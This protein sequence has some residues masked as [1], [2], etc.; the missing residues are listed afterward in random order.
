[1]KETLLLITPHMSTGGCPQVVAKKVELLKDTYNIICVEWECIAYTFVVQRNKVI[2]SLGD[3]FISLGENKEYELFNIIDDFNPQYIMIEELSE[4]FIPNN[5]LKRLYKSDREY[6]IIESTHSSYSN[7]QNKKFL[8][9]KFIFVC[10]H[11]A[12]VFKELDIP[13]DVIEYPVDIKEKHQLESQEKLNL[14]PEWKHVFNIGLFTPGK[15]QG[16][17]FDMCT[18]LE[19][20]KIKFHFIGNMAGNFADYWKPLL[21][22]KPEN[23]VIWG[24]R[25]DVDTFIQA[26]DLFLFPSLLELNPISIKEVL[27]YKVPSMFYNLPIYYNKYND[28]ENITM[29]TGSI[30]KDCENLLSIIK[31]TLKEPQII[32][33]P[34]ELY[35]SLVSQPNIK[36]VHLLLDLE[37]SAD[38]PQEKWQSNIDRQKKSV[39][40]FSK[41]S[42]KFSS[43]TQLYSKVNRTFLPKETSMYPEIV[44]ESLENSNPPHL[45]Y[46]HYGGY[47]A[48]RRGSTQEFSDELD[49]LIIVESD[50]A[51]DVS[52]EEFHKIVIEGYELGRKHNAGLITFAGSK[53]Y[54]KWIDYPSLVEDIDERWE[55]VPHFL[56]G[57]M[58]MIFKNQKEIIK[59]KY[60]NSGWHSPDI[61]IAENFHNQTTTLSLKNPLVYQVTGYSLIDYRIKNSEG[62]Y[63]D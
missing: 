51:F 13:Y 60:E 19:D 8:P 34:T 22:N 17:I 11:S 5:I 20:Y 63:L 7:P 36:L 55:K 3:N 18:K 43:Y 62:I 45:S 54:S 44:K 26:G 59:Q 9:D 27:E 49:A 33:Q 31:P 53:W 23:C 25:D 21:E 41:V 1:M 12:K 16:Y 30:D 57:S 4:T 15:N 56:I 48:H 50:V 28:F 42:T 52:P 14:D 58:Y 10:E 29:L 38:I 32:E 39:E 2:N 24:E 47:N 61:W 40:C 35:R 6:K 37:Y 46:G